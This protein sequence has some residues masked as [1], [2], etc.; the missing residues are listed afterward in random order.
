[1]TGPAATRRY[2]VPVVAAV[3]GSRA[4]LAGYAA[5]VVG[6]MVAAR[7]T[8]GR[9]FPDPLAH[10]VS[11]AIVGLLAARSWQARRRGTMVWKGRSVG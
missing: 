5:G 6:R 7:R 9:Q 1:M 4:G 11:V 8:G 3:G 10:P 2:V